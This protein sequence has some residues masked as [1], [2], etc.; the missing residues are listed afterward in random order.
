M[1]ILILKSD[2]V[3]EGGDWACVDGLSTKTEPGCQLSAQMMGSWPRR[4]G[5]LKES[6]ESL[7]PEQ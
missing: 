4:E 5:F 3:W 6:V 7:S 2:L 1:D